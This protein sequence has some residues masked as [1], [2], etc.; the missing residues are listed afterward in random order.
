MDNPNGWICYC[1]RGLCKCALCMNSIRQQVSKTVNSISLK[2]D[3]IVCLPVLPASQGTRKRPNPYHSEY[4][5]QPMNIGQPPQV[6]RS[7][8][9][10]QSFQ[11]VPP[12][13]QPQQQ[14]QPT[15]SIGLPYQDSNSSKAIHVAQS[16]GRGYCSSE[17]K[18]TVQPRKSSKQTCD[19]S[20]YSNRN[21]ECFVFKLGYMFHCAIYSSV[22]PSEGITLNCLATPSDLEY[23]KLQKVVPN[24]KYS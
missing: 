14:V 5:T 4:S 16:S 21:C 18:S 7:M 13:V 22:S 19:L 1:C 23:L 6:I 9:T 8:P 15:Q 20:V 10:V 12:G 24:V 3:Q 2:P 11:Q 17:A